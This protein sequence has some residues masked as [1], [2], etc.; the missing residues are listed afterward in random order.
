MTAVD[1]TKA[2]SELV[3]CLRVLDSLAAFA[4]FYL[5]CKHAM[6]FRSFILWRSQRILRETQC[7]MNSSSRCHSAQSRSP[8]RRILP[9]FVAVGTTI[10]KMQP[11][12]QISPP[13]DAKTV[14]AILSADLKGAVML[15]GQAWFLSVRELWP[16]CSQHEAFIADIE[17]R[18]GCQSE[19]PFAQ[20][21]S[22]PCRACTIEV[23]KVQPLAANG[24]V[25]AWLDQLEAV[26]SVAE[27]A[28]AA[29][30]DLAC[31]STNKI[32]KDSWTASEQVVLDSATRD[33]GRP[34]DKFKDWCKSHLD[35]RGLARYQLSTL[36]QTSTV[37]GYKA[38]FSNLVAIADLFAE[39][40]VAC[41]ITGLRADTQALS[42]DLA[43]CFDKHSASLEVCQTAAAAI[44]S[45]L[46]H[47]QT[48]EVVAKSACCG[49]SKRRKAYKQ[50]R[51]AAFK[52]KSPGQGLKA[53]TLG[54]KQNAKAHKPE[55]RACK[56]KRFKCGK[57][58]HIAKNCTQAVCDQAV[59]TEC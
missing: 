6:S 23:A 31:A 43:D 9:P 12:A 5:C 14:Q 13:V 53:K 51:A 33:H 44:E 25:T 42:H 36:K 24:N 56:R 2:M 18:A 15:Y 41:W 39:E 55:A 58:G 11:T 45:K 1:T 50:K 34:W 59:E 40:A 17:S 32:P 19:N 57:S 30:I 3:Q 29:W 49:K 21:A 20:P 48:N 16:A 52:R 7:L 54:P 26:F 27:L 8:Y 38:D 37:A 22:S 47:E 4:C 10:D 35:D 46:K 28:E